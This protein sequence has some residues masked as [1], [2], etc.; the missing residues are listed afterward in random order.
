MPSRILVVEDDHDINAL[1]TYHLKQIGCLV[2]QAFD[3]A[4]ALNIVQIHNYDLFVL[5]YMMPYMSGIDLLKRIR[6]HSVAPVIFLT[7]RTD[8]ADKIYALGLG[9][10]DY[11]DKPFSPN[12][13]TS[14]VKASLRRYTDY[15]TTQNQK[16]YLNGNLRLYPDAYTVFMGEEEIQLNPKAFRLLELLISEPGRIFTKEHIYKE[17]WDEAYLTDSNTIMVHISQIRDKLEA[18]PKKPLYIKTIK[19][20]GYRMDKL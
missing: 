8:E 17:V 19:G 7:A 12:E 3:G 4:E 11:I 1:I 20:L 18:N 14:R 16:V 15:Q 13:L 6:L 10:D 2:D 9:A 5:D